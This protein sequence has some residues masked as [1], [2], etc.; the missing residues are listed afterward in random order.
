[1]TFYKQTDSRWANQTYDGKHTLGKYGC[2]ITSLSMLCDIEPPQTA[3][4]LRQARCFDG[5]GNLSSTCAKNALGLEYDGISYN[6][7]EGLCIAET[8]DYSKS[9]YPQHFF[10][11][12][13][14][15]FI[16]DPILGENIVN[17]YHIVSF[18]LFKKGDQMTAQQVYYLIEP[19][20]R[21][22]H[23][24]AQANQ[25]SLMKEC[26]D[27]AQRM[28]KGEDWAGASYRDKWWNE[29]LKDHLKKLCVNTCKHL[30]VENN[31][32]RKVIMAIKQIIG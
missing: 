6:E 13:G 7:Q 28:N 5:Q 10:V 15:G 31:G 4:K 24:M 21:A 3:Q 2:F 26:Q 14:N 1:M 23:S 11:W 12:L 25:A 27:I 17:P 18:R 19:Y 30:E 29:F 32:L 16:N 20:W 9:G 22:L 8:D